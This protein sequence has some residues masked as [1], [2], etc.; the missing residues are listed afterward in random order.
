MAGAS[1]DGRRGQL[2]RSA[3]GTRSRPW[4]AAVVVACAVA[5]LGAGAARAG[6]ADAPTTGGS[7]GAVALQRLPAAWL[8]QCRAGATRPACPTLLQASPVW[9]DAEAVHVQRVNRSFG[10]TSLILYADRRYLDVEPVC[11]QRYDGVRFE[12]SRIT[13]ACYSRF[14]PAKGLVAWVSIST[15]PILGT[16]HHE[17]KTS[18]WRQATV[19]DGVAARHGS[20]PLDFGPLTWGGRE[21]RLLLGPRG[22]SEELVFVWGTGSA[23]RG[24]GIQVFEPFTRAVATVQALVASVPRG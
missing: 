14:L 4:S 20:T 10:A 3:G 16:V 6:G 1:S 12:F 15:G 5:A 13:P 19:A 9:A 2:I 24:V 17:W 23:E 8:R 21:G 22:F 18:V 11:A 7:G